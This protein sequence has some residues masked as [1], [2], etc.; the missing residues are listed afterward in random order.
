MSM[1]GGSKGIMLSLDDGVKTL[2]QDHL[3]LTMLI[4]MIASGR[5][6]YAQEYLFA[7]LFG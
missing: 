7:S 2:Y 6:I 5:V 3:I 4:A 1:G